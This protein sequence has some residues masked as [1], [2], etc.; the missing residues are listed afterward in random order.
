MLT[1]LTIMME[2]LRLLEIRFSV[3]KF[4]GSGTQKILKEINEDF[5]EKRGEAIIE[6]M[7]FT[8]GMHAISGLK[9]AI[10]EGFGG[11]S[12]CKCVSCC[13]HADRRSVDIRESRRI[14]SRS[15]KVPQYPFHFP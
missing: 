8:G 12:K 2:T 9:L 7:S 5:T 11:E 14:P 6:E 15:F 10:T 1:A 13:D 3:I 4:A